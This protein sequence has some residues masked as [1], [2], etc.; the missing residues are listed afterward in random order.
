MSG[1]DSF[2]YEVEIQKFEKP[3]RISRETKKILDDAGMVING[4]VNIKGVSVK[5][6]NRMKSEYVPCP[7]LNEEVMFLK[8]FACRNFQSRVRGKVLCK[9]DPL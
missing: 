6:L 5:M 2:K 8:C 7:V 9:G 3:Q 4:K 1:S